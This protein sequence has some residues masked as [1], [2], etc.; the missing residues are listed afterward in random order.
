MASAHKSELLTLVS[1]TDPDHGIILSVCSTQVSA[2]TLG[3]PPEVLASPAPQ[4]ALKEE[5]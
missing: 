3:P 4:L 2:L 1:F 5:L